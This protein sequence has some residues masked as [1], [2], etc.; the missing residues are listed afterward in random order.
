MDTGQPFVVENR[1]G[2]SGNIGLSAIAKAPGDGY[3]IGL[4]TSNLTMNGALYQR[5]SCSR[6]RS[7]R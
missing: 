4:T 2:A 3:T 1:A 5:A 7:P 6:S